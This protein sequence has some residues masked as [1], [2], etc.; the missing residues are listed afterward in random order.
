MIKKYV[1]VF[2]AISASLYADKL[3]CI[4]IGYLS[5][6]TNEVD[7]NNKEDSIN[8]SFYLYTGRNTLKMIKINNG[9]K[10]LFKYNKT[11]KGIRVYCKS[12]NICMHLKKTGKQNPKIISSIELY[13]DNQ[14]KV[15]VSY[16]ND[17]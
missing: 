10:F 8:G 3:F 4:P 15:M 17:K 9:T 5:H 7:L 14:P 12:D 11:Y 6:A 1:I 16:C 2:L 13:L